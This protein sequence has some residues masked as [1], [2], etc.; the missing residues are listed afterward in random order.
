[1]NIN[2]YPGHMAKTRRQIEQDLKIVDVVIEL[3]DARIPIS[4][5]NPDIA[6]IVKGKKKI[7]VL[8]KCDLSDEKENQRWV[9]FFKQK[10]IPVVLTD[11]NSGKGIDSFIKEIE[12]VM[13]EQLESQ[14]QKGRIGRKIR[15]MILGIPNVGKSSFINRISKRTTA[16]V[17]N[18]PGVTKQKQW[19]RINDKIELLD[20]PGVLWPKFESEEVA[21][22]LAFTGTIKEEILQRIEI[23]YQLVKYLLENYQE[24]LIERY[25]ITKEFIEQTLSQE[26]AENINI[27]EIMIEIGRKRG[28]IISG[29]EIDEEKTARIILDEFKNGKIG[30]ITLEKC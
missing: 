23:A 13:E 25:G 7:I 17:G 9:S 1:M 29:G 12:K 19:I 4:S 8:N 3:L 22:N 27:Y 14:A 6:N 10:G 26:Q 21:L 18:K 20:T 2:W 5:Q 15:A 16:G 11:S 24:K 30:K 28:C